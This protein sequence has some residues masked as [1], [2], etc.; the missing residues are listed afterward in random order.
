MNELANAVNAK[1]DGVASPSIPVNTNP[2]TVGNRKVGDTVKINGIY[3]ASNSTQ[4]LNPARDTGKI[5]KIIS[6][7]LNPYL[8]DNG[9]LGWTNDGCIISGSSS[10]SSNSSS[11]NSKKSVTDIAN[12]VIAGK[13]G[14]GAERQTKLQSAGYD[15]TEVQ[16]M[17]NAILTGKK[18]TV[19]NKKSI[20]E[21]AR[22]V[23]AGKWGNGSERFK[24]LDAA[25][26]DSSA[27]QKRVNQL[28]K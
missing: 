5:T 23:I 6:G 17:V 28:L 2:S 25:G 22:E 15:Y 8:L 12:E 27:V 4:K 1:L 14:N 16:N 10:T 7:A 11:N 21:I 20:D 19:S 18:S 13:W 9:N 26:Y 24:K 3:K